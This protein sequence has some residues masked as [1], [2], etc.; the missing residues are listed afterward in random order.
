MAMYKL[1][2]LHLHLTDDEGWRLE[3]PGL[4]ELT[5]VNDAC[6][7]VAALRFRRF[8]SLEI[9]NLKGVEVFFKTDL[10]T[11]SGVTSVVIC[12]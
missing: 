6:C 2:K 8:I 9:Q 5:Q 11:N 4:E 7:G 12:D 10:R 1:N 3:I